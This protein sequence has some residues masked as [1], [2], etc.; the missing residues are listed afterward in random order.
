[1]RDKAGILICFTGID[2]SGKS[3]FIEYTYEWLKR[4]TERNI[5]LC[6]GT[7][8]SLFN[9]QLKINDIG[10]NRD[11]IDTY[12][13]EIVALSHAADLL[14]NLDKTIIPAMNKGDIVL[15]HRYD[16][17][18]IA[19]SQAIGCTNNVIKKILSLCPE[20]D[21]LFYLDINPEVAVNRIKNRSI[22]TGEEIKRK[23]SIEILSLARKYYVE[24]VRSS[25]R[26]I[27]FLNAEKDMNVTENSIRVALEEYFDTQTS[28]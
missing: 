28:G 14:N 15:T 11:V 23:E 25:Q 5:T 6:E 18:S 4:N 2:G 16:I 10:I 12:E 22:L 24:A 20:P 7:K 3:T 13:P 21:I 9:R 19:Y 17:C 26:K 8:P 1:M 27:Y